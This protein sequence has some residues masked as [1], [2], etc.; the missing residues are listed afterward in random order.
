[1]K[2]NFIVFS[3]FML[4][5]S[6]VNL[7]NNANAQNIGINAT[8]AAPDAGAMLDISSTN[9]GLLIPRVSI[10]NLNT[11]A[12]ITGSA[13]TS[14][15]VY[16]TAAT[17]GLGYYYW[18]GTRW[19]KLST[20]GEAWK[21]TGNTVTGTNNFLGTINNNFLALRT[22][23]IERMRV[24]GDGR[25]AVNSTIPF[26]E[27]TFFSAASGNDNAIDGSASG[28]GSAIY[29]QNTGAGNAIYGLTNNTSG[30]GVRG[31]NISTSGTGALFLGQNATGAYSFPSGSGIAVN[32]MDVGV[33]SIAQAT[34]GWGIQSSGNNIISLASLPEGGGGAFTGMQWGVY[35]TQN[36]FFGNRAAFVGHYESGLGQRT[37]YL[38]ANVGGVNYKVLGTGGAS[39]ST[40]MPTRDGERILF[41]PEAPENWFFDLGEVKLKDGKATVALDPLFIDCISD[42]KPF[43]VFI[44]GGENTMGSIRVSRNQDEKTFT[45]EDLGGS[46]DGIVQY[47][48]YAI[49]RNKEDI[50]FPKYE[51]PIKT[52]KTELH[53]VDVENERKIKK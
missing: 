6:F 45:V 39:V 22:N 9:K 14:M 18:D 51:E 25:V 2:K 7:N 52:V 44:Q 41:A 33:L 15:L 27:S 10:A 37:V 3:A 53:E 20:D 24:L 29:G 42:A 31:F 50:R 11:I 36:S 32:A 28:T 12:P 17:T 8:G 5:L 16:N 38:G 30:I 13:T 47:K 48:I 49:W 46:S 34:D 35:A 4:T 23:N 1:M 19:V 40:T 26:T 21:L 43:K